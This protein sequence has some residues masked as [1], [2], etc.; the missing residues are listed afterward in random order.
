VELTWLLLATA[1]QLLEGEVPVR[2]FE[3]EMD[4]ERLAQ[5]E[6][7]SLLARCKEASQINIYYK[8]NRDSSV[9]CLFNIFLTALLLLSL[10][11][12]PFL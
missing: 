9:E 8:L 6:K 4:A 12:R 1:P 7:I 2:Y 11:E 3:C 5:K 10:S